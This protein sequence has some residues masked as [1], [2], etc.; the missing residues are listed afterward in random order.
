MRT[1]PAWLVPLVTLGG[2]LALGALALLPRSGGDAAFLSGRPT[3]DGLP[4]IAVLPFANLGPDADGASFAH[5]LTAELV[6]KLSGIRGLRVVARSSSPRPGGERESA[7]AVAAA[8]RVDHLLDGS[9]RRSGDHLRIA[10]QLVDARRDRPLWSQTFDRRAGDV[11]QVQEEIAFAVAAALQVSLLEGDAA[12]VRR[13]LTRDPEANR[14]YWIAYAHLHGRVPSRDLSLAKRLLERALERDPSFAAAQ[15]G[16]ARFHFHRAWPLD[17][18][19][20]ESARLGDLAAERAVALD[21]ELSEALM[22]RAGFGFLRHRFRGDYGAYVEAQQEM[23][24]AIEHDPSNASAYFDLCRALTWTE[25]ERAISLCER[26]LELDP[27][28]AGP[29]RMLTSLLGIRGKPDVARARCQQAWERFGDASC[30]REPLASVETY[31]GSFAAALAAEHPPEVALPARIQRWSVLMALGDRSSA[32]RALDDFDEDELERALAEAARHA[33]AGRH[34]LAFAALDRQREQFPVTRLLD[35]PAARFALLAGEPERARRILEQ[36]IPDVAREIEPIS[37]RNLL[38]ALDLA[39]A[40]RLAG[41]H[42]QARALLTRITAHLDETPLRLPMI[43]LQRARAHA[44]AGEPDAALAALERA[45]A[46]GFRTTWA[47]DLRPQ[48]LLY[49]DPVAADPAFTELRHD[50]RFSAWL[51]RIEADNARVLGELRARE[52]TRSDP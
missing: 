13:R 8:L 29:H 40:Y 44:L 47:V 20:E 6:S 32:E 11:L 48:P 31:A 49:L 41:A 27:I 25:P 42:E 18:D 50:P 38:P 28:K 16:I 26:S 33:M 30:R 51:A 12:R 46:E 4:S 10:A 1:R 36:R 21:P 52:D 39:T 5:G 3:A 9:V 43:S 23:H 45:Y 14:L 17:R 15:A 7:G 19:A 24:R 37:G 22:A 2:A 34:D 35:A